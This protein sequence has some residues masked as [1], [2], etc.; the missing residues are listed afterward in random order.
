M[1]ILSKDAL[2]GASDLRMEEIELPALGGSVTVQSLPAA[3]A[4]EAIQEASEFVTIR[5]EQTVQV[6]VKK[7]QAIQVLHGLIDP[8]FDTLEEVLEL[9][10]HLGPSW[11]VIVDKINEL[12]GVDQEA[13]EKANTM[14][15]PG[16]QTQESGQAAS[17]GVAVR[18]D[19]SDLP[20]RTGA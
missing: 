3:F 4:I 12:T 19:G 7:A 10:Q 8:K 17:N 13:I 6:N 9:Q 18:D 16:G 5:G 11:K 15:Q 14:F 1:T 20:V 2:K